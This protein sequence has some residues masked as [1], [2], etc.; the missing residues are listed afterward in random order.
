[1]KKFR[2]ILT[3]GL[4]VV[5]MLSACG[6]SGAQAGTGK[7]VEYTLQA[8]LKDG[9][10]VY[11]GLGGDIHGQVN[12]V[13]KANVGDTVKVTLSSI[14]GTEH[15]ISFLDFGIDSEHV[16]GQGSSVTVTF[17]VDKGGTFDYYCTI[18]GH[19][20]AGMAGSFEVTGESLSSSGTN[21]AAP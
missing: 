19:R 17:F 7:T 21:S 8:T 13:L 20:E 11:I 1:M 10:M 15:N 12:P 5:L 14:D 16:L 6:G 4:M 18:P 2:N 3:L 9:R